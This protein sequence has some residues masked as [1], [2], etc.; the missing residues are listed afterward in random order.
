MR[1][2]THTTRIRIA[3]ILFAI[4]HGRP[5]RRLVR[6]EK[7]SNENF[8]PASVAYMTASGRPAKVDGVPS[9]TS[10]D[11]AVF[12]VKNIS[13]DGLSAEIWP[14]DTADGVA[15]LVI[16]ADADLG[17]GVT[18]LETRVGIEARPAEAAAGNVTLGAGTPKPT[19]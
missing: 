13:T 14:A 10:T 4:G 1:Q 5:K 7:L 17:D 16:T 2:H 11:G 3:K 15:E 8:Y 18:N 19:P 12:E 6:V 9:W